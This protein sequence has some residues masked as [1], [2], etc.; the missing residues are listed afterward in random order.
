MAERGVYYADPS[1]GKPREIDV[2][3]NTLLK[4]PKRY[5][6]VGAPIINLS[7]FC[8]CKSLAGSNVLLSQG[9]VPGSR[10]DTEYWMG[11]EDDLRE[12]VL[13]IAQEARIEDTVRVKALYD[14][15]LGRAYPREGTA[16]CGPISMSP[17]PVDL[18]ATT[19][20]ET[21]GG[22]SEKVGCPR[23][24]VLA[25]LECHSWQSVSGRCGDKEVPRDILRMD[26]SNGD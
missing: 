12:I 19:F 4:R 22:R 16:I 9:L 21:K 2:Y 23:R 8:E 7:I 3:C 20:R 17:P 1:T 13:R 18:I 6:G 14:Y 10:P 15:V 24:V 25:H 11:R 26:S 5:K